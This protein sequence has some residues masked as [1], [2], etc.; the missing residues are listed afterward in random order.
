MEK[1]KIYPIGLG[2]LRFPT[3]NGK[4]DRQKGKELINHGLSKGMNFIDTAFLYQNGDGEK[5]LGEILKDNSD[6][7][8]STKTPAF[9][10][11]KEDEF[12]KILNKQL[13]RLQRNKID[14]YFLHNIDLKILKKMIELN[15]FEFIEKSK[16]EGKIDKIGF[17][18][19]G[20][21][22][23]LKEI[24]DSFNWDMI[25]VQYNYFDNNIQISYKEIKYAYDKNLEIFIMEPLKG[26]LL[27]NMPDEIET[28]FKNKNPYKSCADWAHSWLLNHEEITCILSGI[29]TIE[30][31]DN[32]T[33]IYETFK[34]DPIDLDTI[35]EVKKLMKEKL[36]INC[37]TCGY[38]LPCPKGVDIPKCLNIYNE[39]YLFNKKKLISQSLITYAT[40]VGGLI[41]EP[42][43]AGLCN[44]CGKCIRKCPQHLNIPKELNKVKKEFEIPGFNYIK[45]LIKYIISPILKLI[46]M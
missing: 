42:G 44:K 10:I 43:N 41:N 4:I 32:N 5:L 37:S 34:M 25:M 46:H 13:K 22:N 29:K 8:I 2:T 24:I 12:E 31:I 9:L 35:E 14:Y 19:H 16:K 15:I 11:T 33:N 36:Q 40:T 3:K 26:G 1:N 38:C 21:K 7:L 39:K 45:Y 6:I 28:I 23:K 18:Y 27:A 30:D 20:P 17:S